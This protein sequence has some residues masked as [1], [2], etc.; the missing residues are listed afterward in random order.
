MPEGTVPLPLP[1]NVLEVPG[2]YANA[3]QV[4]S[5]NHIDVRIAFNEVIAEMGG[6]LRVERR[7]S[8]VMPTEAFLTMVQ[9]LVAN[10]Q[11]LVSSRQQQAEKVRAAIQAQIEANPANSK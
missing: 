2:V 5:M 11:I 3:F 7:A 10:T 1:S 9:L 6:E 4:L 8:V